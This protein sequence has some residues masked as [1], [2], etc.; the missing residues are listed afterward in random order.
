MN[1]EFRIRFD[2]A[3]DFFR[4]LSRALWPLTLA[5]RIGRYVFFFMVG[6]MIAGIGF[7]L[8]VLNDR[9]LFI[10]FAGL[11][12]L[13]LLQYA[14]TPLQVR[15][16]FSHQKLGGYKVEVTADEDGFTSRTEVSEGQWKWPAVHHVDD[17]HGHITLRPNNRVG[18]IV[19][20]RAFASAAEARA[21]AELAKEK[22][23][24][25]IP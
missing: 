6:L 24:G 10:Y 3:L 20:I 8:W 22:T 18:W 19:P 17:L 23:A 13:L 5:R 21:F 25:Q 16:S 1:R 15:H 7:S 9:A 4:A 11:A 12:F 2:L 14:I